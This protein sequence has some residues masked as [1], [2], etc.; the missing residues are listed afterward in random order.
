MRNPSLAI[1][2][3]FIEPRLLKNLIEKLANRRHDTGYSFQKMMPAWKAIETSSIEAYVSGDI[4]FSD[5]SDFII[6]PF[7]TSFVFTCIK[8]KGAKY[9][10][11]WA[12]S[13]S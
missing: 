3:T 7:D 5:K 1:T 10:L 6:M 9:N 8:S 11:T 13:L 12:V 2:A 4:I